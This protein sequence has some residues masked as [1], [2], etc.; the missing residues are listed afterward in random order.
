MSEGTVLQTMSGATL[1]ISA[2]LPATYDASGYGATSIT[3]TT[4][5]SVEDFGEHGGQAQVSNF[6]AVADGVVQK[7]KGSIDYGSMN[8]MLGQVSS[9]AGQDLIDT[10]FASKNR[11]SIKV[12]YPSRTGESTAEIHYLDALV[13]K[14]AWQDGAVD[15]VRKV[16]VTL[17][18]CRAPVVVAAT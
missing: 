11:Y 12:T 6:V 18:I 5:G 2:S 17:E 7:F 8:V 9:D 13:T 10:A 15:N 4:V 14:R 16:S 3:Y 1:G